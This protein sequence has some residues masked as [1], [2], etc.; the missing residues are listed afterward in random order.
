VVDR[1][2]TVARQVMRNAGMASDGVA[3]CFYL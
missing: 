1:A 2:A 3:G